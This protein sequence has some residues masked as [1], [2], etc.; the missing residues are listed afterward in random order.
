MSSPSTLRRLSIVTVVTAGVWWIADALLP[1]SPA[2]ALGRTL[3]PAVF[4][5][6][7]LMEWVVDL[8][9]SEGILHVV[10]GKI[11]ELWES[12]GAGL[13]GAIA[14]GTFVR[15][16][17]LTF[18]EEWADAGSLGAFIRSEFVETVIGFSFESL[19]NLVK[20]AVWFLAWLDFPAIH[21]G[22]LAAGCFV[23]YAGARWA[24]PD[25]DDRDRLESALE[26]LSGS[27]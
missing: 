11:E 6:T 7:V 13:Y 1:A 4:L 24:W 17:V 21:M 27:R 15:L 12:A 5:A 26:R 14:V 25:P 9:T 18:R 2:W 3:I 23:A 16:E 20:A 8:D 10:F 19:I 22:A